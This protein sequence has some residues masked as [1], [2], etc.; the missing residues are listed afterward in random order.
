MTSGI[1]FDPTGE[2]VL[3]SNKRS[4]AWM[5]AAG[6]TELGVEELQARHIVGDYYSWFHD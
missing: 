4:Q 3:P 1:A 2:I 5:A 6:Q